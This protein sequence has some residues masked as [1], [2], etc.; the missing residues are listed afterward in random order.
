MSLK[1]VYPEKIPKE[2]LE[3][4]YIDDIILYA[5]GSYG[6]LQKAEFNQINKTTF[7]KYLNSLIEKGF[8]FPP[9]RKRK[10]AIYE[11]T[12]SGQAEL[13]RRL[14]QYNLDFYE[15]IELEQKKIRA[16]VSQLSSFFEK[17]KISDEEVKI[18]FLSLYNKLI[19]DKSLSIF[20]EEQFNILNLYLVLNDVKY[21]KKVENV[22]TVEE[23]IEKVDIEFF[24]SKTDIMMFIQEVVDKNRYG[25]NIF[26]IP[27]MKEDTF[28]FF[29]EDSEI[30]II[31]ETI[32]KKHL[33][34][35]NYLK[36]LNNSRIYASDL[37]EIMKP[38]MYDLTKKYKIFNIEIEKEI[39]HLVE[40]YIT[41]LQIELHEKQFL[42]FDKIGEY[43]SIYSPWVG[44]THP[45]KPLSEEDE[46]ELRD[47]RTTFQ[48]IREKEPKNKLLSE[49]SNFLYD[50]K[51]E[52]ALI[53]VNKCLEIDSKDPETLELKS[54]ILYEI[55]NFKKA[56]EIFED[57]Q[58]NKIAPKNTIDKLY[59]HYFRA[60]LY[61]ALK[62]Y[63]EALDIIKKD[64]PSIL[65]E[66]KEFNEIE[67][68]RDYYF[69]FK[70]YKL[71]ST[72]HYEQGNYNEALEAI[73]K[74]IEYMEGVIETD[75]DESTVD[76][77]LFKSKILSA[78]TRKEEFLNM[79]EK[80]LA[81]KPEDPELLYR[82]ANL[83]LFS[84]PKIGF[85]YL[86]KALEFDANNKKYRDL[87]K[88]IIAQPD[89]FGN[90][91]YFYLTTANEIFEIL[92]NHQE[93]LTSEELNNKLSDSEPVKKFKK[94][95][96]DEEIIDHIES[97]INLAVKS[98]AIFFKNDKYLQNLNEMKEFLEGL[99]SFI[100]S[101]VIE[102]FY[103][104]ILDAYRTINWGEISKNNL[105]S[106]MTI[107][108]KGENIEELA[109]SLIENLLKKAVLNRT[110][111]NLI[112]I[113]KDIFEKGS[114]KLLYNIKKEEISKNI[115]L[116]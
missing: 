48:R 63:D 90:F 51:P 9:K 65:K 40:D 88:L 12:P 82:S 61:L 93:G 62:R 114:E 44:L 19:R 108:I 11:I 106:K 109:S 80:T 64:I 111:G 107:R 112:E 18:D 67:F 25:I 32:I 23:F 34:N 83:C 110:K 58:Q 22:L 95:E 31:F 113:D 42:E 33:R 5:L 6:P 3:K 57:A 96:E 30:G 28:L 105:I 49:I 101:L 26:K 24:L 92:N 86:S 27:L 72:I 43:F 84:Y 41:N 13:I 71:E 10:I 8:L 54:E 50:K 37:E 68:F 81:L 87:Y 2:M 89:F 17:Y 14:E 91:A 55:G 4:N 59:S 47:I 7:Y 78:L 76:R 73:D 74:D 38:I 97:I 94:Y 77:Y 103:L 79:I 1:H 100:Y 39:F 16:Q 69:E 99:K 15:L 102:S 60:E 35:L 45:F 75:D 70:L 36:S 21:F 116:F 20:S 115:S 98:Q 85:F 66:D 29:G 56:L 52:Q 104:K 53:E 46:Q